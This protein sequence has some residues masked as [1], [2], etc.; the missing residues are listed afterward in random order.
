MGGLRGLSGGVVV[1]GAAGGI[2]AVRARRVS[3]E[4][5]QVVAVD[6]DGA[7]A[8]AFAESLPGEAAWVDADVSAETGVA[9]L[10]GCRRQPFRS[11]GLLSSE[12]RH[13]RT[14]DRTA[15]PDRSRF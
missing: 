12:R 10:R 9:R 1:T 13:L 7:G 6:T 14:A 3:E 15:R 2:G 4:G 11:G 5:V 8:K